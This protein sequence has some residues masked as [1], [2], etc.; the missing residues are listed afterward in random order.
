MRSASLRLCLGLSACVCVCVNRL[1]LSHM[2]CPFCHAHLLPSTCFRPLRVGR[3]RAVKS[4]VR[5]VFGGVARIHSLFAFFG[6]GFL[7]LLFCSRLLFFFLP[8]LVT[9]CASNSIIIGACLCAA[10][11]D[12][13]LSLCICIC[14]CSVLLRKDTKSIY[15]C[16]AA[17]V[18]SAACCCCCCGQPSVGQHYKYFSSLL[19]L[20]ARERACLA[21]GSSAG[22]PKSIELFKHPQKLD[23][24][25][26]ECFVSGLTCKSL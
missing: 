10:P 15:C 2:L 5:K 14:I 16:C 8:E 7:L 1:S 12:L 22:R 3:F 23:F 9:L 19:Q 17:A 6:I 24:C 18:C 13:Y 11:T 25:L 4:R 21:G 20:M 26:P